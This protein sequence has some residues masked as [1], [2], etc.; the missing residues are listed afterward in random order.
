MKNI[1]VKIATYVFIAGLVFSAIGIWKMIEERNVSNVAT[2][3]TIDNVVDPKEEP[4]YV[5]IVGGR[6]DLTNTYEFTLSTKKT[7]ISLSI[8]YYTPVVNTEDS[9][10]V[11][12]V[13]TRTEPSI[14]DFLKPANYEGLL[15]SSEKLPE[16]LVKAYQNEL[17]GQT[18]YYLD[19]SYKPKSFV[20]KLQ[21]NLIFFCMLIGGYL[22]RFLLTRTP[23]QNA[24]A[25]Q[26]ENA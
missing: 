13:K 5:A 11:Y 8:N 18:Y 24:E 21:G 23:K 1:L 16:D 26:Q 20:E 19:S 12:I 25:P 14:A 10:V 22:V 17:P 2:K 7:D 15:Q 4:V 9:S 6:I 3:L